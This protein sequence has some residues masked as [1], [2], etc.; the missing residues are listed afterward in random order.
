MGLRHVLLGER[1]AQGACCGVTE[2]EQDGA[3]EANSEQLS[4]K[5]KENAVPS[6][7]AAQGGGKRTCKSKHAG[8]DVSALGRR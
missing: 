4:L 3:A 1:F 2:Q 7:P 8:I 6:A 5:G